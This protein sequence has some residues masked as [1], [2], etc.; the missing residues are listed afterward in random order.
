[1]I[2]INIIKNR[3]FSIILIILLLVFFFWGFLSATY[4]IFPFH[5]VRNVHWKFATTK[6]P[7][8]KDDKKISQI[9]KFYTKKEFIDYQKNIL[10]KK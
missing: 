10:L 8:I 2:K 7:L 6:P 4:K 5:I 1:M 9:T 3:K